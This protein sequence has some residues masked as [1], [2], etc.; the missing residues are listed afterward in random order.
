MRVKMEKQ[1]KILIIGES[2]SGKSTLAEL[3]E[4]TLKLQGMKPEVID[5]HDYPP[6]H[7]FTKRLECLENTNVL[8]EVKQ[9]RK[10]GREA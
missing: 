4:S 6:K 10:D 3:I 5:T 7:S 1:L 9:I 8:I 2:Y